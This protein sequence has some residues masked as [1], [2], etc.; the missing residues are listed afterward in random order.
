VV[1]EEDLEKRYLTL[2]LKGPS[3]YSQR[4]IS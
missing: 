2:T 3:T 1:D 4:N